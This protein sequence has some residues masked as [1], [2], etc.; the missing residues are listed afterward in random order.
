MPDCPDHPA[1]PP[2]RRALVVFVNTA[3]AVI[4]GGLSALLGVFA[5]RPPAAAGAGRWV[6]AGALGDL[7]AGHA[8]RRA[9][10]SVP[11]VDG[12]YRER[13][14]RDGLS[15]LG[16]PQTRC[17]RCRRPARISAA[18]SSGTAPRNTSSAR[19]TAASTTPDGKVAQGRRRAPS[20][21]RGA[22][23]SGRRHGAGAAVRRVWRGSGWRL[24]GRPD[25]L[26]PGRQ[27]H[28]RRAAAARHRLVLHPRQR[29][30]RADLRSSS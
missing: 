10:C 14:P 11:R 28:A 22:D 17:G 3:L 12:W 26:P 24:A 1:P 21:R 30:A 8:D 19:V 29:S 18:R 25:R 27:R 9:F 13:A 20:T 6:R 15:R 7:E 5:L 2:R 23:R 16:R 4:G